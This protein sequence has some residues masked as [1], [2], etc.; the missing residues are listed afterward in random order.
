MQVELLAYTQ[1]NPALTP[2]SVVG[3]SDL[4][5]LWQGKGTY[6]ESIIEYAGRVCY[7]STERMGTAP[8]FITARVREG[9]EDI[10]EHIVVTIQ[11]IGSDEPL[12]WRMVN[13]HCEVSEVGNGEWIVSGNIRVWLDFFRRGIALNAL[14][15]MQQ[16]APAVFAEFNSEQAQRLPLDTGQLKLPQSAMSNLHLLSPV[17]DGPMRVTLLGFTQPIT[18]DP[19]VLLQHGA[20]VFL[21]EGISRTCTHQLVRHRLASFSQESQRYCKYDTV[22]SN[23]APSVPLLPKPKEQKRH[24]L[25]CFTLDQERFI[26]EVYAQEFSCEAMAEAYDVDPTTIRS[27]VLHNGGQIRDRQASRSLHIQTDFFDAIDTPLKA[28][29]LGL[30]YADGNVAQKEGEILHASIAQHADYREW[31]GR[32]GKLW[33]GHVV[34]GGREA[35]ARL[36]IPGKILA[37]ALVNHGVTPAKSLTLQP[38][39]L[40]NNLIK[41]FILGYL[42]GDGHIGRHPDNPKI[43]FTGTEA[44]LAWIRDHICAA[45]IKEPSNTVRQQESANCYQLQF[46]GKHQVPQILEWLYEGIDYRYAHPAKAAKAIAWSEKVAAAFQQQALVWGQEFQVIVPPKFGPKEFSVYIDAVELAAQTYANLREL[47]IRKED[48]RFLLPN[49]AETRIVT[50]MN[51]AAWS[52]FFWLR[53]VDKAAQWEIRAMGQQALKMLY[54]VAPTVF[55]KHWDVYEQQFANPKS[56]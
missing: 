12:R 2:E 21:F 29:I 13:R 19:E 33:G 5:R 20:A 9:H 36:S 35:S 17:Q 18:D 48:A 46:N 49:A 1:R 32:L 27:I 43:T 53:A 3:F 23:L 31:L 47:G 50:S 38:P 16:I 24:G 44:V 26:T 41:H 42:E 34:S 10:I 51:Y 14:P 28:Q 6:A 30:I 54:T 7:R 25:S 56:K 4:A 22:P 37:N 40:D 15:I 52:H 45:L 39:K 11:I 55:Q 8:G